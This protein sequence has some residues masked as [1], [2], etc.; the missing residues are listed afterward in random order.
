MVII[1]YGIFLI[2]VPQEN[3]M[4]EIDDEI[5]TKRMCQSQPV[6]PK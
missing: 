4:G 6:K 1:R 2:K 3:L 5:L